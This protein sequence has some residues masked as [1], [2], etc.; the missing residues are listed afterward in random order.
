MIRI[1]VKHKDFNAVQ[2][3]TQWL[4]TALQ[5]GL[6]NQV[7]GPVSPPVARVRN[8]FLLHVLVKILPDQSPI[9]IK[10]YMRRMMLSFEAVSQFRKLR[11]IIDVDP[12]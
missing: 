11:V 2:E 8:Q 7:L 3:G 6:G 4:Y 10:E 5:K 9:K 1:I 12:Y